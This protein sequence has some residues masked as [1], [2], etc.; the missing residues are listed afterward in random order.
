[1]ANAVY[2]N[3][4][5]LV[6]GASVPDFLVAIDNLSAQIKENKGFISTTL[7]LEEGDTWADYSVWE[8]MDDLKAFLEAAHANTTELAEKFYS[9]LNFSTCK[10]RVYTVERVWE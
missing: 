6:K 5:K 7:L 8:T 2:Y 1:M 10:S 3:S 4:Y 9:F